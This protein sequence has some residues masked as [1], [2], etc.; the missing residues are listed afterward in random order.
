MI[1][2]FNSLLDLLKTFSDEQSCIDHFTAVKWSEKKQCPHCGG[3]KIY[4]F[5]D[6]RTHKCGDCRKK[7]SIRVGT[8]FEDSKI[9][10]QKWFMAIYLTTSH[11]K[12]ISSIQLSKDIDVTQKTAW[13]MLHRLRHASQTASFKAQIG[14]DDKIVEIDETYVGGKEKNKHSIKRTFSTHGAGSLSKGT[15]VA[16]LGMIA[17]NGDLRMDTIERTTTAIIKPL[18]LNNV[19]KN[20]IINTDEGKQYMFVRHSY[21]HVIVNHSNREY[22]RGDVYTNTIEGAFSHFKRSI[23][24]V[25]HHASGKHINRYLNMFAWRWNSRDMGEGQRVNA[26][27]K[28]TVGRTLTYKTLINS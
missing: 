8:I 23:I 12:G 26:L 3:S 5:S 16:V 18:V 6:N 17:R 19:S 13:F 24:G 1:K 27:L 10:L 20:A 15:K 14:G 11:K 9:P 22:V 4:H 28:S 25:Y 7:F 2:Q 21:K